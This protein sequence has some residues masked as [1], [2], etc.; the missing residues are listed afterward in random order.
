M[1][2]F[3]E[4]NNDFN[5][6]EDVEQTPFR[7]YELLAKD[8]DDK[9]DVFFTN[10]EGM[11]RMYVVKDIKVYCDILYYVTIKH[12]NYHPLRK[13]FALTHISKHT[14]TTEEEITTLY[15]QT[16]KNTF[17]SLQNLAEL[18]K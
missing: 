10:K 9:S 15:N 18:L 16:I 8:M 7:Y 17:K 5:V 2:N 11:E 12:Y 13:Q 4:V 6:K 14:C 1:N 3:I